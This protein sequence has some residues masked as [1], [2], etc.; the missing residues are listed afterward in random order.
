MSDEI[1]AW[2]FLRDDGS[3]RFSH[4]GAPK[5]ITVGTVLRVTPPLE[6]CVRGLH[7]SLR[8]IDALRYAPGCV[9]TIVECS[10]EVIHGGRQAGLL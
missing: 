9:A 6:L 5:K 8:T 4:A 1:R 3:L 7:A 10:G 2:H